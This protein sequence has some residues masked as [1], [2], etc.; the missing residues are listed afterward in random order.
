M[1]VPTRGWGLMFAGAMALAAFACSDSTS[2]ADGAAGAAGTGSG[3]GGGTSTGGTGGGTAAAC[4][5]AP[6][7]CCTPDL[8]VMVVRDGEDLVAPDWSCITSGG[9]GGSAGMGAAGAAGMGGA[10]RHKFAVDDFGGS[11]LVPD[12]EVEVF[13]GPRIV[14]QTPFVTMFTKGAENPY[15]GEMDLNNGEFFYDPPP[16]STRVSY[17]VKEKP[18]IAKQF[19]G[20]DLE[21]I[22]PPGRTE[23]ATVTPALF[24]QLATFAVPLPNWTPPTDLGLI[25]APIRDCQENDVGGAQ[26]RFLDENGT[27]VPAGEGDRDPRYLYFD[28]Q[29]PN[30]TCGYTDYRQS[31][32]LVAN[33]PA[34]DSGPDKG[35]KLTIE[36][37]GRM[38]ETDTEPVVFARQD[39]EVFGNSV[40]VYV[41]VPNVPRP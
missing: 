40:N 14:D 22:G 28:S 32:M 25:A 36:V 23:G 19:V 34:N 9:S 38:F 31:L 4:E 30:P 29:F 1:I 17:R 24:N 20:F 16:T 10:Q 8:P 5:N 39:L 6:P 3:S 2:N 37:F 35:R 18:G 33:S 11:G 12:V 26:F 7:E 15:P 41:I 13:D 27:E 21:L